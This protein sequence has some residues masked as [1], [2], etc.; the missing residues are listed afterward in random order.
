VIVVDEDKNII[1]TELV[2]QTGHEPN[3]DKVIEVLT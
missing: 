3:Y 1:Y 2:P